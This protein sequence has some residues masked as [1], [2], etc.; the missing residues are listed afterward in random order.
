MQETGKEVLIGEG[1][2]YASGYNIIDDVFY[3][4]IDENLLDQMQQYV[5]DT[6]GYTDLARTLGV[7]LVNLHSGDMVRAN[8]LELVV[9]DGSMA[10]E[11]NGPSLGELVQMDLIIAGTNP[12]A[13]DMVAASIMG[14]SPGE[15]PTFQWA[16]MAGM[17][18]QGLSQI[19]IRGEAIADVQRQFRRPQI[20][21]WNSIRDDFGAEEI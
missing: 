13:T 6:L 21:T 10:M 8:K 9:I 7:P 16:N 20:V 5:F 19:E 17:A 18:P 12:L 15:I 14:F 4:T 2:A 3:R 1:S 11:G